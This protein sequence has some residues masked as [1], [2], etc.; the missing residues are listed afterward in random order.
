MKIPLLVLTLGM[1]IH[2]QI[3]KSRRIQEEEDEEEEE[4]DNFIKS[5]DR[6]EYIYG[7]N[8]QERIKTN[9]R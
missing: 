5:I 2:L 1:L 9:W 4:Q 7:R 3:N 6:R 8:K